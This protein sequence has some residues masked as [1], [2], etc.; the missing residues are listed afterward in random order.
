[1]PCP[2]K[3]NTKIPFH[4]PL[5]RFR[6]FKIWERARVRGTVKNSSFFAHKISA[7][8]PPMKDVQIEPGWKSVLTPEFK[9]EYWKNLNNFVQSEIKGGKEVFPHPQNIFSAYNLCPFDMTKVVIL[10]QDPYHSI[11]TVESENVPTAHGLCFSVVK[12]AKQPPSLKNIFKELSKEYPEFKIPEHGNLEHWAKQGVLLLNATLT[13]RAHEPMSHA[14]QGWEEFTDASI[15]ALSEEKE[16]LIFLLWGRHAKDKKTLIDTSKH[17][18]LEAAHPSPFS[19]NNGFFGCNHF[20][21]VNV[22]LEKLGKEPI[23]WQN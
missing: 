8:I 20:K 13:V 15:R 21:Q 3:I 9:T 5:S 6:T 4:C 17:T 18:I 19:A 10:G 22:L 11:S 16:N 1:M 2:Y 14:K 7:T 12:G 23:D